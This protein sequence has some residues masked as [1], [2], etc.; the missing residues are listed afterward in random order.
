MR[1]LILLVACFLIA[2][3]YAY[4]D[5]TQNGRSPRAWDQA[6]SSVKAGSSQDYTNNG[7]AFANTINTGNNAIGNAGYTVLTA[8]GADGVVRDYYIWVDATTTKSGTT[9]ELRM[10]SFPLLTSAPSVMTSF[11]YGD[12]RQ[13]TGFTSSVNVATQ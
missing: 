12:W 9:G 5:M 13:S 6:V 1:K 11:P 10:A 3:V 7:T 8:V 4:A 2:S